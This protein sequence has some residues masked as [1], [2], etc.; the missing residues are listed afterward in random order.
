MMVYCMSQV[1]ILLGSAAFPVQRSDPFAI[2]LY[3]R[4]V[5]LGRDEKPSAH[6]P[7][8]HCQII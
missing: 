5:G 6:N 3:S 8:Q 4:T 7:G 1:R 2:Q